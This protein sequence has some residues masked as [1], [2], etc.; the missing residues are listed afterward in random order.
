MNE[1]DLIKK[2][3]Q[4]SYRQSSLI[5]GIGDDAAVFHSSNN[6]IVTATDT[7]VDQIHFTSKTVNPW[8]LGYR[9]LA[10]NI[11]DVA[12]MGAD[13]LFYLVNIVIPKHITDSTVMDIFSGMERLAS[14]Y[15]LDLI[16]GDTVSGEQLMLSITIIGS[17]PPGKARYRSVAL[18]GDVVFVT[19]TLGDA[20]AGLQLLLQGTDQ[21]IQRKNKLIQ[22]HQQPEP[23]VLFAQ[24]LQP[25]KRL[26]L[27]D[28]SDGVANELHEIAVASNVAIEIQDE[29]VPISEELQQFPKAQQDEWKYFGGEDFELVGTVSRSD[30]PYVK[31]TGQKQ[32]VKV[33]EIGSVAYNRNNVGKV[34]IT[35]NK[36]RKQLEKHGYI[37][38]S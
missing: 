15:H 37:H 16:G 9:A 35:K 19:G 30:F 8:Q 6:D 21:K 10:A 33:T 14:H 29:L 1:F 7:F 27:N 32:G 34:F 24:A 36:E 3:K 2:I 22:K 23:R 38:R 4:P 11:S 26:A 31:K 13:P 5:K 25:L 18:E 12:A 20:R 17:V 28:I